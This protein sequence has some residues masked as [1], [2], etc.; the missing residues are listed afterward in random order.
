MFNA[1]KVLRDEKVV[2]AA[3]E[4]WEAIKGGIASRDGLVGMIA[5]KNLS[6]EYQKFDQAQRDFIN[7]TLRRES[8]AAIAESEFQNAR[9]Q[10]FPQPGDTA[11]R[12]AQKKANRETAIRGI[13]ASAGQGYR[14]DNIFDAEGN[15]VE[16]PAPRRNA[17]QS[18]PQQKSGNLPRVTSPA[19]AARLPKGTR[20]LD[21]NGVERIVP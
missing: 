2:N 6:P 9:K 14:P 1:E 5:N 4:P 17:P 13:A 3:L 20:F 10:Y 15:V 12:I 8:G 21:P 11:D 7:A 16:N 19:D 18:A